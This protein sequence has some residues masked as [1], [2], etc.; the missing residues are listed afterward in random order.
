MGAEHL[1]ATVRQGDYG[2]TERAVSGVRTLQDWFGRT[3]A[4][5]HSCWDKHN[6]RYRTMVAHDG[7]LATVLQDPDHVLEQTNGQWHFY[8]R[9]LLHGSAAHCYLKIVIEYC[10]AAGWQVKSACPT[11][12]VRARGIR[13][14]SR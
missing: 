11:A 8:R 2:A 1:E 14:W 10:G 13:R 9:G 12:T 6:D 5:A 3:I 4:L 7:D